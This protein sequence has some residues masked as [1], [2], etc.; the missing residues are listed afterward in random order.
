MIW[1]QDYDH[2]A[3]QRSRG[4][5]SDRHCSGDRPSARHTSHTRESGHVMRG[6]RE[7]RVAPR[8]GQDFFCRIRT[9][10]GPDYENHEIRIYFLSI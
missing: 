8:G 4:L 3:K 1:R 10:F 2:M 7:L 6:H 5:H 9:L